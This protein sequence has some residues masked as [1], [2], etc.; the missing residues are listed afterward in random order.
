MSLTLRNRNI[1]RVIDGDVI[2]NCTIIKMCFDY[3]VVVFRENEYKV[4]YDKI[5]EVIGH[6][7]LVPVS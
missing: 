1:I 3:V 6:E 5:D 2:V 4:P 7:L